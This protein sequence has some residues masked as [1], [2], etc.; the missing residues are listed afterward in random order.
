MRGAVRGAVTLF[1]LNRDLEAPMSIDVRLIGFK[2][3]HVT[4]SW[5]LRH[6]DLG[7]ANTRDDPDRVAP[8]PRSRLASRLRATLAPASWNVIRLSPRR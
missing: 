3:A 7:A 1:A 8:T 2:A 5:Q 4:E 6:D